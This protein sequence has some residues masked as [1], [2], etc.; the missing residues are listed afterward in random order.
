M[1]RQ[2]QVQQPRGVEILALPSHRDM[3]M[4]SGSPARATAQAGRHRAQAD[5]GWQ[6]QISLREGLTL[7]I[8]GMMKQSL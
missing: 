4:R 8:S 1:L 6:P 2:G 7:T 3:E 5:F